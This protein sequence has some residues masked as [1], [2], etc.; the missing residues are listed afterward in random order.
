MTRPATP[1]L[2]VDIIIEMIDRP[3]RPVVLIERKYPPY[4]WAIPGG[5]V[6]VGETVTQ[7][8]IREAM[9]ETG[10]QVS[11]DVLLGCYSEPS[12]DQ[13]GHTVSLVYIAQS[14][15]EPKAADD[16]KNLALFDPFNIED[17]LA[18]DHDEIIRD[19]CRYR[20]TGRIP[21]L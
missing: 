8:A 2:T 1:A 14:E 5:F 13:R 16:A 9:E 18:F 15:G 20:E 3:E 7:A 19:Y 12:R 6:D 10:L 17:Q 21:H 4:G 11:L